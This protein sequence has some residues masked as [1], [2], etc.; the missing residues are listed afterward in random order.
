VLILIYVGITIII[1]DYLIRI[2]TCGACTTGIVSW[3]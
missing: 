3:I 2:D 1:S